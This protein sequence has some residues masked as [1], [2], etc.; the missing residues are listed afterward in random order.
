MLN[1]S[2]DLRRKGFTLFEPLLVTAIIALLA[3]LVGPKLF[4]KLGKGGRSVAKAQ[5]RPLRWG[6]VEGKGTI[7]WDL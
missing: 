7:G 2:N 1:V 3:S 6:E 5:I 4:Q